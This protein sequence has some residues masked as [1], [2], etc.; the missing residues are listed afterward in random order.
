MKSAANE[1]HH[2]NAVIRVYRPNLTGEERAKRESNIAVVL[3]QYGKLIQ[4][5]KRG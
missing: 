3:Q 2:G 1:Y 5:N 4:T